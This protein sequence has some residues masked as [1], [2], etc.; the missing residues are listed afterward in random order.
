MD[1]KSLIKEVFLNEAIDIYS[2]DKLKEFSNFIIHQE[3]NNEFKVTFSPKNSPNKYQLRIKSY[4]KDSII[5]DFGVIVDKMV[6]TSKT[7]KDEFVLPVLST[8][9]SLL[10]Y[11][12][13]K[14]DIQKFNFEAKEGVRS[15]LYEMYLKKHFNDFAIS[16]D[17]KSKAGI[18]IKSYLL[19]KN[20]Q[21]NNI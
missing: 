4:G 13:D 3:N 18:K 15:K 5:V 10:R 16:N 21:Q 6:S 8:V 1:I 11:F 9:F 20:G 7:I 19:V 12:I 14:Y 17:E 2:L